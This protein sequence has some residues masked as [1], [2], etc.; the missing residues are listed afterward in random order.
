MLKQPKMKEICTNVFIVHSEQVSLIV[1]I[2]L[3]SGQIPFKAISKETR[4]TSMDIVM[5]CLL[6]T[7][8]KKV[9]NGQPC[10]G[11]FSVIF[12]NVEHVLVD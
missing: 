9:L 2:H 7:L 5:R 4:R 1:L 10:C 12:V 6:L 3:T 8:N 11:P